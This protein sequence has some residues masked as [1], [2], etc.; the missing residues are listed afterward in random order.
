MALVTVVTVTTVGGETFAFAY[1]RAQ[2]ALRSIANH[3]QIDSISVV[4]GEPERIIIPFESINHALTTVTSEEDPPVADANCVT[5][6]PE[7]DGG[8]DK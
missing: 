1:E 5:R 4:G 8:D 2:S 6:T 7:G 3:E